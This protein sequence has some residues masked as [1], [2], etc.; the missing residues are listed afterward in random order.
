[1]SIR[2]YNFHL[3]ED[4][5]GIVIPD[6]EVEIEY[7]VKGSAGDPEIDVQAIWSDRS[8]YN[9]VARKWTSDGQC[10][11]LSAADTILKAI[12]LRI[13]SKVENDSD[14]RAEALEDAGYYHVSR[15]AGDPETRWVKAR[16]AEEA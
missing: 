11:L 7:A 5:G 15:G 3:T 16:E 13:L 6:I 8:L 10:D 9:P 12:G 14:W 2:P 4:D 1:M